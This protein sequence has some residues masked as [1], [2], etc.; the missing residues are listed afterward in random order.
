MLEQVHRH[1]ESLVTVALCNIFEENNTRLSIG[2]LNLLLSFGK[3]IF[4][5]KFGNKFG[6]KTLPPHLTQLISLP[7]LILQRKK[8]KKCAT[9]D[10]PVQQTLPSF[11][12]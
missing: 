5:T 7:P 9:L 1:V 12:F 4:S 2:Y 6:V 10:P 3:A 11:A 8:T